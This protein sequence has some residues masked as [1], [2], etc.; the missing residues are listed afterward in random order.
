MKKKYINPIINIINFDIDIDCDIFGSSEYGD[1]E[2]DYED[3][4]DELN[5]E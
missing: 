3:L 4:E 5:D 2:V 1:T